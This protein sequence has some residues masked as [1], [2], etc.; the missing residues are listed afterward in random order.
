M[1][2]RATQQQIHLGPEERRQNVSQR[3]VGRPT[4]DRASVLLIDDIATTGATLEACGEAITPPAL[5][6][7]K[8]LTVARAFG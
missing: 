8:A 2:Q 6:V 3:S 7:W 4:A 1:L 5:P